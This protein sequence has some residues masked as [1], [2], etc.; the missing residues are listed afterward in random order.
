MPDLIPAAQMK[1]L[2]SGT[3]DQYWATLRHRGTGP[4]YVK[5]VRKIYYSRV[6]VDAWIEAIRYTRPDKPI[7]ATA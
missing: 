3:S 1:N 2:F 6:D 4:A 7:T 5:V